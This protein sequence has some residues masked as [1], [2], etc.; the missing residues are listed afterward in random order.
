MRKIQK[1]K[2]RNIINKIICILL[3][4][5]CFVNAQPAPCMG[6]SVIIIN[7]ISN[8]NKDDVKIYMGQISQRDTSSYKRYVNP[9]AW[10]KCINNKGEIDTKNLS[11]NPH[12]ILIGR[13]NNHIFKSESSGKFYLIGYNTNDAVLVIESNHKIMYLVFP[14]GNS[15]KINRYLLGSI[16]K[17]FQSDNFKD[18]YG[19]YSPNMYLPNIKFKEGIFFLEDYQLFNGQE[20]TISFPS[21]D[22][23]E[24]YRPENRMR[25]NPLEYWRDS[26]RFFAPYNSRKGIVYS[27]KIKGTFTEKE[28]I[29]T[30]IKKGTNHTLGI[31]DYFHWEKYTRNHENSNADIELNAFINEAKRTH[32]RDVKNLVKLFEENKNPKEQLYE[33]YE[34]LEKKHLMLILENDFKLMILFC[35]YLVNTK[36]DIQDF[37]LLFEDETYTIKKK[38]LSLFLKQKNKDFK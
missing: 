12:K 7:S 23:L 28:A 25:A 6:E 14:T 1:K 36:T 2:Q 31:F 38:Q 22:V 24:F 19:F 18:K 11:F 17:K 10:P 37:L 33:R 5:P 9:I 20:K 3:F 26:V 30:I 29:E 35:N 15:N 13:C 21:K 27:K 16:Y 4:S 8:V 32:E 34:V